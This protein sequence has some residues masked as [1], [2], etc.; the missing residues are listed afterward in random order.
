MNDKFLF[1]RGDAPNAEKKFTGISRLRGLI[2]RDN[3]KIYRL[4]SSLFILLS[5]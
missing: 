4:L 5:L 2:Y 1:N 3:R